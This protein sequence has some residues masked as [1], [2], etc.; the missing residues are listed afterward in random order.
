MADEIPWPQISIITPSYNQ[1][2]F[3]ERTIRSVLLQGY[4]NLE[5]IIIDGGST[6]GSV[7]IIRK[8][9]PWLAYWVSEKDYGQSQAINKGLRRS[10]G[11]IIAWLNSDDIYLPGALSRVVEEMQSSQAAIVYGECKLV[12]QN[13]DFIADY[14]T[15]NPVTFKNLIHY[16]KYH[17][18]CPPQPAVFFRRCVVDTVG[19]L[20]E[21]LHYALDY[22]YWLRVAQR[23]TFEPVHAVLA[24]YTVHPDSKTGKG[25]EPFMQETYL[26][27]RK[28]AQHLPLSAR[29]LYRVFGLRAMK[30]RHL[31]QNGFEAYQRLDWPGV[32]RWILA[33]AKEDPTQMLNRGVISIFFQSFVHH[34]QHEI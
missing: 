5:Y 9:E 11:E 28:H 33:A 14:R 10:S 7:E 1:A 26:S 30:A 20:D 3:L 16:W 13:G 24:N 34:R 23:Y 18:G 22:E 2:P 15:E 31:L 27:G 8:Y 19:Y 17:Y 21:S 32:R 6:D 4:P 12:D 25:F 29:I